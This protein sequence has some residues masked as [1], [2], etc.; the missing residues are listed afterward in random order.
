[1]LTFE[2]KAH[3]C[4][5][6]DPGRHGRI[7][8]AGPEQSEV[9]FDDGRLSIICN[10]HLRAV[11]PPAD[12][13]DLD[14]P[15]HNNPE[16]VTIHNGRQAWDHLQKNSTWK[17]WKAVGSALILGRVTAMRDAHT[18]K[19]QGR[20]YCAALSGWVKKFGFADL[21]QGDRKRL[22]DVM[23]RLAE[24]ETWLDQ[25]PQA[26]RLRLNHPSAVWRKWKAATAAPK[27]G[28]EAK[29]SPIQKLKDESSAV[30]QERDRYRREVDQGGGDLWTPQDRP[31][32]IAQIIFAKVTKDKAEKVARAI[33][34]MVN[35]SEAEGVKNGKA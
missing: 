34:K 1:M 21:D 3:V 9:R 4:D 10:S 7:L 12:A 29:P 13:H 20:G 16:A 17:D 5:V 19:P 35:A 18:N 2:P 28:A 27:A 22:F 15:S 32:D 24:V 14:G 30:I 26:E 11:E 8:R 23:D 25:L 31:A 33:L 6:A